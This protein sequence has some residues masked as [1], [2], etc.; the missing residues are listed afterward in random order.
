MPMSDEITFSDPPPEAVKKG[1]PSIHDRLAPLREHPGE[2]AKVYSGSR[3]G[4]K[5]W[6][7]NLRQGKPSGIEAGQYDTRVG[8]D[9]HQIPTVWAA[10]VGG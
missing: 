3:D 4:A 2:W 6:A 8:V 5:M 10:Y 1:R 9:E 7:S